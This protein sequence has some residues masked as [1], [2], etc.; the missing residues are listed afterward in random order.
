MVL[1]GKNDSGKS[2]LLRALNLFFNGE[3]NPGEELDF[4]EDHNIYN[5]PNR[6]AKE[7]AV[8][9]ELNI[10]DSYKNT[11]GDIVVW[12][13]VWREY[14]IFK[15]EYNGY[16]LKENRLGN[17]TRELVEIPKKSNL[18]ALLKK[19][20]YRY[21]P[22]IKDTLFF[23]SLRGEIYRT[24]SEVANDSFRESSSS[25]EESIGN[26]LEGLTGDILNS[27]KIDTRMAFPRDLTHIF[28]R[29]DFLGGSESISLKSRGDGIK[30]RHIPLI[31]KFIADKKR[32]V[33]VKGAV[34]TSFIWGYEEPENNIEITNCI[35]L[36]DEFWSFMY[37]DIAQIILTTHSP[38]FY[39]L[40]TKN[41][42]EESYVSCHHI[43]LESST[44]GTEI[45]H[46]STELDECMGTMSL[47]APKK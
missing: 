32:T 30:A 35:G 11:N 39:N 3:V 16:R 1:V 18:H 44:N 2:N 34:P 6:K 4:I 38:V 37:N 15:N 24:I 10:P 22:A 13:K 14:G 17:I 9:I 23:D 20:E 31:L 5:K 40:S 43:Y 33:S 28:E 47:F 29:L 41:T 8:T 46:N 27:L 26:H 7:I 42:D 19:I 21:I 45:T 36:A 12:E 25:F